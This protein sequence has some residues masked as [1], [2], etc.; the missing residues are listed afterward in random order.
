M[1][2]LLDYFRSSSA[3][4]VRIA[5]HLKGV[6]YDRVAVDLSAGEQ[7]ES[8][9]RAA[10]PQGLVPVYSDEHL[11]LSQ[12]LAIIEYLDERYPEPP[13]LPRDLEARAR[14]RQFAQLIVCD[15]HPLNGLRV[16]SYL[17]STLKVDAKKRR[18]WFTHWIVEGLDALELWLAARGGASRYCVGDEV[19]IA[20]V[21]L[22]PQLDVARRNRID[23]DDFPRIAE[24]DAACLELD[25]FR[26]THP[27][28]L[29][30]GAA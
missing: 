20:D 17:R 11:I 21:C 12:S 19:S 5:L 16:L 14:A 22:V 27:D 24:I 30:P 13:L 8:E 7:F 28:A 10:N 3:Y 4:R 29:D 1:Y 6:S 15:V 23:I 18:A 2:E 9:F 26:L 25:A